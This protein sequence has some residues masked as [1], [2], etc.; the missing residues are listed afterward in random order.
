M[1][2]PRQ[3][4]RRTIFLAVCAALIAQAFLPC[5]VDNGQPNPSQPFPSRPSIVPGYVW[6]PKSEALSLP[7]Y[8]SWK[9]SYQLVH[10]HWNS[11]DRATATTLKR[12][13]VRLQAS[14][15][16]SEGVNWT[17]VPENLAK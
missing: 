4:R 6:V 17:L 11:T 14:M 8:G 7:G 3:S 15:G 9:D 10:V 13:L 16:D 12:G 2:F 5:L 1:K